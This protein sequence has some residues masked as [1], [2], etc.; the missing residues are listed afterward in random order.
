MVDGK[1]RL[2][3]LGGSMRD[4]SR[5]RA[6]L[7]AMAEIA[8]ERGF[9]VELLDVRALNLPIYV[10]YLPIEDYPAASH[11]PIRQ[12]MAAVRE[13]DGMVWA[14]PTYHGAVSGV[15]KIRLIFLNI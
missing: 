15:F 4:Q 12:L 1:R 6:G 7:R 11:A 5:S 9:E 13:A 2:V 14:S 3:G 8:R 10:P